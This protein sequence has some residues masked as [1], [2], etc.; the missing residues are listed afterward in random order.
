L[1]YLRE[2][3]DY[4]LHAIFA[5]LLA[6]QVAKLVESIS[7]GMFYE[8]RVWWVALALCFAAHRLLKEPEEPLAEPE[9]STRAGATR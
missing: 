2:R 8:D 9:A 4:A 6:T 3:G 5:C 1:P 7:F